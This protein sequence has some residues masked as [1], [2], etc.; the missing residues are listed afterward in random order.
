LTE[1]TFHNS[2]TMDLYFEQFNTDV[3]YCLTIK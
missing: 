1:G 3:F 2:D